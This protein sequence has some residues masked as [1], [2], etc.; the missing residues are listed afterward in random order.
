MT[1]NKLIKSI[2]VMYA[3][4]VRKLAKDF[5]TPGGIPE[6]GMSKWQRDPVD[7]TKYRNN[8]GSIIYLATK[9]M[10]GGANAEKKLLQQLGHPRPK[11]WKARLVH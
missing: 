3:G 5:D 10:V 1:S 8:L 6:V 11:H 2:I 7:A 4:H 9:I